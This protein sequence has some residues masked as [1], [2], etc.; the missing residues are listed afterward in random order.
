MG[1][2]KTPQVSAFPGR[3]RSLCRRR[4]EV[5]CSSSSPHSFK[6]SGSSGLYEGGRLACTFF[7]SRFRPIRSQHPPPSLCSSP[8]CWKIRYLR[9]CFAINPCFSRLSSSV[10]RSRVFHTD[11]ASTTGRRLSRMVPSGATGCPMRN[12]L[13]LGRVLGLMMPI[14]PSGHR[15]SATPTETTPRPCPP[16]LPCTY[17]AH[18]I[19]KI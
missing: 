10:G 15:A 17:G 11:R 18:S 7:K 1:M 4:R 6:S 5:I 3:W 19:S 9:A 16:P 13:Q 14:G 12:R 8:S 2:C